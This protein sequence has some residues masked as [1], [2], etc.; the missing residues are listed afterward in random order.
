[1]GDFLSSNGNHISYFLPQ[2][3]LPV[4]IETDE[5]KK[6]YGESNERRTSIGNKRE[7]NSNHWRQA[8]GHANIDEDVE[9]EDRDNSIGIT[10]AEYTSLSFCNCNNAEK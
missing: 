7:W 4:C 6:K 8:Y 5:D 3:H 9:K 2:N 1:M 10:T